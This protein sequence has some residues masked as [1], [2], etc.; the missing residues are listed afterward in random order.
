MEC[1]RIEEHAFH[2]GHRRGIPLS[3]RVIEKKC[4]VKCPAH[5]LNAAGNSSRDIEVSGR[6]HECTSQ[7]Q[8]ASVVDKSHS[9][10]SI[11]PNET[12]GRIATSKVVKLTVDAHLVISRCNEKMT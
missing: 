6:S 5:V 3:N 1:E 7:I 4:V 12:S 8:Q 10:Q 11:T 9:A 2:G